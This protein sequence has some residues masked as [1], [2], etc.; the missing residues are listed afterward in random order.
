MRKKLDVLENFA[1]YNCLYHGQ[2]DVFTIDRINLR[3]PMSRSP[4]MGGELIYCLP[5]IFSR[6]NPHLDA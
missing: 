4:S 2:L 3:L 5:T 1:M 6:H